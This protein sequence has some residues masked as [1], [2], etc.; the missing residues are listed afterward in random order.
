MPI[1]SEADVNCCEVVKIL[2]EDSD[3][4]EVTVEQPYLV[5]ITSYTCITGQWVNLV[6]QI[7]DIPEYRVSCLYRVTQMFLAHLVS[8]ETLQ[9]VKMDTLYILGLWSWL[10]SESLRSRSVW[11]TCCVIQDHQPGPVSPDHE[12]GENWKWKEIIREILVSSDLNEFSIILYQITVGV[13][14]K[15][16]SVHF[17]LNIFFSWSWVAGCWRPWWQISFP[18]LPT[19]YPQPHCILCILKEDTLQHKLSM[20]S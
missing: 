12:W 3:D 11:A 9:T 5:I 13:P 10:G 14:F 8:D 4:E 6:N 17:S 16:F 19:N 15:Y 7:R 20:P 2:S 1:V 18:V